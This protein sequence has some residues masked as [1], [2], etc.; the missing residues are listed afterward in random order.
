MA[1]KANKIDARLVDELL[2]DPD[3]NTIFQQDGLLD[4]LK[5]A[6]AERMLDTEM[7]CT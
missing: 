3:P 5:K 4:E 2:K 6:L 7:T 1:D